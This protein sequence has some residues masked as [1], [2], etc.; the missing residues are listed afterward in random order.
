M[1][2]YIIFGDPHCPYHDVEAINLLLKVISTLKPHGI[3]CT[4]DFCDFY[5]VSSYSKD[6]S[7]RGDLQFEVEAAKALLDK[8]EAKEKVFIAGN[9]EDRLER[10]IREHARA[11]FGV[12]KV[13]SLLDLKA[14]EWRYVPYKDYIQIGKVLFTHDLDYAGPM[15]AQRALADAQKSIVVG[16]SHRMSLAVQG[17]ALGHSKVGAS[18]GWLGDL[19]FVDYAHKL[20][21]R[22]EWAQGFGVGYLDEETGMMALVPVPIIDNGRSKVCLVEGKKF[23][24]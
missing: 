24:V 6:P 3:I 5:S 14:K 15:V 12:F 1:K 2:K 13:E 23:C 20:K 16:H 21:S 4:G 7:R 22:K 18:F 17:D 11:L 10:Y 8:F 19:E 9:H